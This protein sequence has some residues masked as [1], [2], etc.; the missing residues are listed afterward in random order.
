MTTNI[1]DDWVPVSEDLPPVRSGRR[2]ITGGVEVLLAD[3]ATVTAFYGNRTDGWYAKRKQ[4]E[5]SEG[6]S[7]VE[8]RVRDKPLCSQC[9]QPL[10]IGHFA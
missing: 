9:K 3:G 10:E 8:G 7:G 5:D 2:H 1:T 4:T 6:G